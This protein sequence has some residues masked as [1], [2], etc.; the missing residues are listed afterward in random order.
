[1]INKA[2]ANQLGISPEDAIG[3]TDFDF[4]P[5]EEAKKSYEEDAWILQS[6]ESIERT[7]SIVADGSEKRV[8]KVPRYDTQGNINGVLAIIREIKSTL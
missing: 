4:L 1:L 3:K 2:K 8:T 5:P 6:G 7:E